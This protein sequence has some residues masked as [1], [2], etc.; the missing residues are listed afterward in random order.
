MKCEGKHC[1]FQPKSEDFVCP[2][3]KERIYV[4]ESD[5]MECEFLHDDDY[6]VCENSHCEFEG[7]TG[8]AFSQKVQKSKNV[9]MEKC[10][11]CKGKG[12]IEV[13]IES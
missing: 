8:K 7:M 2:E 5:F 9:K 4:D 1:K 12:W 13:K 3:C 10:T 11:C 6:I